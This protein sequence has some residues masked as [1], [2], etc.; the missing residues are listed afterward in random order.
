M[1]SL[2]NMV[3]FVSHAQP[4]RLASLPQRERAE[5]FGIQWESL[6][7]AIRFQG[8]Q[9][10][11]SITEDTTLIN[12]RMP[13]LAVGLKQ[14]DSL[15]YVSQYWSSYG[16]NFSVFLDSGRYKALFHFLNFPFKDTTRKRIIN[17]YYVKNGKRSKGMEIDMTYS[18]F[19]NAFYYEIGGINMESDGFVRFEL[20]NDF[21]KS[22][23]DNYVT[24]TAFELIDEDSVFS[25][26]EPIEFEPDEDSIIMKRV[27]LKQIKSLNEEIKLKSDSINSIFE[28]IE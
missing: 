18:G 14:F 28:K 6:R 24:L 15:L 7:D 2:M 4:Y 23:K 20:V 11:L 3:F 25:I 13:P 26:Y 19:N 12:N 21:S 17:I 27:L 9:N 22:V 5:F 8:Q 10:G 16:L 1:F